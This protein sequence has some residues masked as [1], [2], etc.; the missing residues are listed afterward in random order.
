MEIPLRRL[1]YGLMV[2]FGPVA[3][4]D[5]ED[6]WLDDGLRGAWRLNSDG[7]AERERG[8][9]LWRMSRIILGLEHGNPLQADHIDGDRLNNQRSNLRIVTSDQNK[10]NVLFPN[11]S[12]RFRGVCWHVVAGKWVAYVYVNKKLKYLGYYE[13]ELEAARVAAAWRSVYIPF[14]VKLRDAA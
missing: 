7:Y 2:P 3:L 12:S 6:A 11:A 4:V 5:D 8:R 9:K 14:A 13:D 1:E 10:Q